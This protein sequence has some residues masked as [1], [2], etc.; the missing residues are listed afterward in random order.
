MIVESEKLENLSLSNSNTNL[1]DLEKLNLSTD[2]S[3][4]NL[5][6]INSDLFELA[7]LK[8]K[9]RILETERDSLKYYLS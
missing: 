7:D 3:Q 4:N 5:H 8:I 1:V 9:I 6:K 2:K